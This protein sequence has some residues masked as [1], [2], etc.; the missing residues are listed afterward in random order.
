M[1]SFTKF[2]STFRGVS[3]TI[4][5]IRFGNHVL[6][7]AGWRRLSAGWSRLWKVIDADR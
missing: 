7:L 4:V 3:W 2:L 1:E 6:L 5:M